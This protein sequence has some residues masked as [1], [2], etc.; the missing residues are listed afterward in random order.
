MSKGSIVVVGDKYTVKS[1]SLVGVKG[2]SVERPEEA[3]EILRVLSNSPDVALVMITKEVADM[4][5]DLVERL[6]SRS[7]IPVFTVIPS[8]W[9]DVRPVDASSLLKKALGIG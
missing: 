4:V 8:R 9:A 6:G 3:R 1:F 7:G 2:Y 5:P